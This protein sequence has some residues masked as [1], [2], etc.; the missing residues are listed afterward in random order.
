[1]HQLSRLKT[2]ERHL[3]FVDEDSCTKRTWFEIYKRDILK[4]TCVNNIFINTKKA[5]KKPYMFYFETFR[6]IFNPSS[7]KK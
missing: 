2:V 1:M 3:V 4:N 5:F 6:I 7:V